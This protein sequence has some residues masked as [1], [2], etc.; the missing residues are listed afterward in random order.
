MTHAHFQGGKKGHCM[1]ATDNLQDC[2][3]DRHFSVCVCVCLFLGSCIVCE[4]QSPPAVP[5]IFLTSVNKVAMP[6][7]ADTF[8]AG[9]KIRTGGFLLCRKTLWFWQVILISLYLG[10]N[11]QIILKGASKYESLRT[12][13]LHVDMYILGV[14]L[15][16]AAWGRP[17]QTRN[18]L[19][20]S[21]ESRYTRP[22]SQKEP[23][24]FF[25][26]V[27]IHTM[28]VLIHNIS[29]YLY[30]IYHLSFPESKTRYKWSNFPLIRSN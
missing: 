1:V 20:R 26:C 22:T 15:D 7:R 3:C 23:C 14:I 17:Q 29:L 27:F 8:E 4:D 13:N 19:N 2:C 5:H 10:D 9:G 11:E 25:I 6:T 18:G 28:R 24:L 16:V 12:S 30:K 21:A